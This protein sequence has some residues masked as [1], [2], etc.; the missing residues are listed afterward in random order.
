MRSVLTAIV[1]AQAPHSEAS[2]QASRCPGE[3]NRYAKPSTATIKTKI[4]K[5]TPAQAG[6]MTYEP[7]GA[8]QP[9]GPGVSVSPRSQ[10]TARAVGAR[11]HVRP[12]TDARL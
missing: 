9:S 7:S 10:P 8:T 3:R 12:S 1:R 2:H 11:I 5:F 6:A 4:M